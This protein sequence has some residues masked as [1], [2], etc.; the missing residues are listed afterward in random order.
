MNAD[1]LDHAV[2]PGD[3]GPGIAA[4]DHADMFDLAPISLWAEDYSGLN[5]L[6]TAWR[7]AGVTDLLAHLAA[8]ATRI[9][10]CARSITV[11]KVNRRTLSLYGA[12]DLQDL[13][14][15]LAKIMREDTHCSFAAELQQLWQGQTSFASRSV[16]YSIAGR[17]ID[18]RLNGNI[19]PGHEE[20]WSR[21]LVAI[22]D[23]TT[24]A[25]AGRQLVDAE[26]YARALFEASPVSLWV[27][28]FS[29]IK[30][31]LDELRGQGIVDFRIFTDVYPDF[32][33]RC[34]DEIRVVDVN[35]Y[36]LT[37]FCAPDKAALLSRLGEVFRDDMLPHFAEQLAALWQG[38]LRQE[39]EVI[40]YS[41]TGEALNLVMQFSVVPG[42]EHDWSLV[43]LAFTDITARKKAEAYLE[44]LG[45]HD[46][47]TGV[48][49]RAFYTEAVT[50]LDRKGPFPVTVIVIDL[51]G[52]KSVN[53]AF[54]HAAG[55]ALLRR[56]A[57]VLAQ[58]VDRP[59]TVMRIGGDEFA[60]L[61]PATAALD[62][63][64]VVENINR[65]LELNN[66]FH[67][68]FSPLSFAIGFATAAQ[69]NGLEDVIRQADLQMYQAKRSHYETHP[70]ID[71][72]A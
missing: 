21:V 61:M 68:T 67:S 52:L 31:R 69:G 7:A 54:G 50:R 5:D 56:A 30:T 64:T 19:L 47:L 35:R 65:L 39:R 66:Q 16:N 59:S 60:V 37:L 71:R 45:K 48:F 24:E 12:A 8:D 29:V 46:V 26:A 44:Y 72:R 40:N 28:D 15:N 6:F 36:T 55:D 49:N 11:L 23:I 13:T 3:A 63:N 33:E 9:E 34:L 53:D 14:G 27:E 2:K 32:V 62:V 10:A 1:R 25:E 70:I 51:N 43:L 58:A 22:E 18:I 4:A 38:Q 17:R 57:E 41:L 42:H 20:N